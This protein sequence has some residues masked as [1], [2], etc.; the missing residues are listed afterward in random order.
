MATKKSKGLS[1]KKAA[2]KKAAT[3][4][5]SHKSSTKAGEKS[6]LPSKIYAQVSPRSL[7]GVS[8]FDAQEQIHSGTVSNFFSEAEVVQGAVARL[9]EAG[10]EILQISPMM[11]NI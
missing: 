11:I 2:A 4:L 6:A 9:Q 1:K 10:F 5:T 8:M 3:P 7:G